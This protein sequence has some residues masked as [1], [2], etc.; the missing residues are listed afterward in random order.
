MSERAGAKI[1]PFPR[2]AAEPA[3]RGATPSA[4]RTK[5]PNTRAALPADNPST[6]AI[7]VTADRPADGQDR[8][9]QALVAL[10]LALAEQRAAMA[11]WRV[12]LERLKASTTGLGGSLHRYHNN[13]DQLGTDVRNLQDQAGR[14][15]QWAD[16]VMQEPTDKEP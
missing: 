8:L 2:P 9:R 13:L 7:P 11:K 14:L 10:D 12:A 3:E 16:V 1:I 15:E 4:R 5:A 6:A